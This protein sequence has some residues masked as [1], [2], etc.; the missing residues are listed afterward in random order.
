[1]S[2]LSVIVCHVVVE[3]ELTTT[4]AATADSGD[5]PYCHR[6][7]KHSLT[8]TVLQRAWSILNPTAL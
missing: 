8:F 4:P 1:M 6:A 7:E 5:F 2:S 3:R